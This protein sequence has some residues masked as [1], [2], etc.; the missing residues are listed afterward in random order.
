MIESARAAARARASPSPSPPR[1]SVTR[2][3][4]ESSATTRTASRGS[5]DL[6]LWPQSCTLDREHWRV[7]ADAVRQE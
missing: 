5:A 3:A 2:L 7:A 1:P 6:E 4:T